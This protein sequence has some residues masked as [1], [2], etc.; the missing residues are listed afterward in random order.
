V[1]GEDAEMKQHTVLTIL[2][3]TAL[4]TGCETMQQALERN[5]PSARL[6][7]LKFADV[8]LDSATLL[9]DVE[10]DNHY[11]VALPLA[12]FDYAVSSRAEQFLSGNANTQ[13]TVPAKSK[14]TVA[15]SVWFAGPDAAKDLSDLY[16]PGWIVI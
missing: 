5:R 6:I 10:I 11:P 2:L 13:T 12:N 16:L 7:G 8:K 4:F 14:K 15:P 3:G 1:K 9:F